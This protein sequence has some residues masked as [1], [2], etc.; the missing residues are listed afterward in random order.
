MS[1]FQFITDCDS[2]CKLKEK[3]NTNRCVSFFVFSFEMVLCK[4]LAFLQAL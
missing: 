2:F 4:S 1:C 3:I